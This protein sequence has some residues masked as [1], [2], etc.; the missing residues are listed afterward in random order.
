MFYYHAVSAVRTSKNKCFL[1]VARVCNDLTCKQIPSS[2]INCY[3]TNSQ[4]PPNSVIQ[5]YKQL[6]QKFTLLKGN[7]FYEAAER[8]CKLGRWMIHADGGILHRKQTSATAVHNT[9][10][11]MDNDRGGSDNNNKIQKNLM[12]QKRQC[13]IRYDTIDEPVDC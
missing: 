2:I 8:D 3:H 9:I 10:R 11:R 13:C 5:G 6:T 4:T 1:P 7:C 12:Q